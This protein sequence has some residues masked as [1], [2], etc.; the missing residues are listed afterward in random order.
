MSGIFALQNVC[1]ETED[2]HASAFYS[3]KEV[4]I[5]FFLQI[6]TD[7]PCVLKNK[8]VYFVKREKV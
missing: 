6:I 7:W 2:E 3:D 1:L 5:V 4:L 8:A